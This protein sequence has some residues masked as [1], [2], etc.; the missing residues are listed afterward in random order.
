MT[1]FTEIQIRSGTYQEWFESNPVL[2]MGEPGY[3]SDTKGFKIGDGVTPWN[4]LPYTSCCFL[5]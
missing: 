1:K 4:N 2:E 5:G 3:E